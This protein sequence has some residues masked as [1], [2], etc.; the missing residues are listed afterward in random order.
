MTQTKRS[1]ER[2]WHSLAFKISGLTGGI[3]FLIFTILTFYIA[4]STYNKLLD[5]QLKFVQA[6]SIATSETFKQIIDKVFQT[7]NHALISIQGQLA[8]P[9]AARSITQ[10]NRIHKVVIQSNDNLYSSTILFEPNAFD[11]MD[12]LSKGFTNRDEDGRVVI[13]GYKDA[14]D[15]IVYD[16]LDKNCYTVPG[17]DSDWYFKVKETSRPYLTDPYEF[18]GQKIITLSLPI[19][20]EDRFVGVLAVDISFEKVQ[21]ELTSRSTENYFY[22]LVDSSHNYIIHGLSADYAGVP[23]GQVIPDSDALFATDTNKI[24]YRDYTLSL[25]NEKYIALAVPIQFENLDNPWYFI[26]ETKMHYFF[27]DI[28]SLIAGTV[29][30]SV[31]ALIAALA[32]IIFSF[33][34][35]VRKPLNNIQNVLTSVAEYDFRDQVIKAKITNDLKRKDVIGSISRSIDI[36]AENFKHLARNMSRNSERAV[37]ASTSLNETAKESLKLTNEVSKAVENVS[38]S[39][40]QQAE[41][42]QVAS[43]HVEDI[44]NT[45][46]ENLLILDNLVKQTRR[47]ERM[48]AEGYESLSELEK[49]TIQSS[50][51]AVEVNQVILDTNQSAQQIE[52]ASGMIQSIADQ[53]NLL[54]LNAAIEAAR[55]GDAG[56][57]FAVV[58]EEIRKLAEQ[59]TGF[60]EEIK[61]VISNLQSKSTESVEIMVSIKELV[62][63]Q[64]KCILQTKK[65]FDSIAVAL[66]ET[67][68]IVSQLKQTSDVMHTKNE[69]LIALLQELSGIAEEN[70]SI[71]EEVS[72][73][74]EIQLEEAHRVAQ[75][76]EDITKIADSLQR[77][78]DRFK[79]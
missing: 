14:N 6:D 55:A 51:G 21:K 29:L 73:S 11:G 47:I 74:S 58:A 54:A 38:Q 16:K 64:D 33:Q 20:H 24:H 62:S 22:N 8:S 10:L 1:K 9:A 19:L 3:L 65:R 7:G 27:K 61:K 71:A 37:T 15:K 72:A 40:L 17:P 48:K 39:A 31:I 28:I 18:D 12:H 41:N 59:S 77:E 42:T 79:V 52:K 78:V 49:L 45:L 56:M 75:A 53:T 60:A 5:K 76:G 32:S 26:S 43:T 23:V 4:N 25:N 2:I 30:L 69:K 57:G 63:N 36:M 13:Y 66:D 50:E 46:S 35:M 68:T 67:N 34:R 70:S 44:G